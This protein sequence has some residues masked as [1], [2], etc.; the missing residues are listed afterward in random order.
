MGDPCYST[1]SPCVLQSGSMLPGSLSF[2]MFLSLML[3]LGAAFVA[4]IC[5][6]LKRNNQ[7]L[8]ELALEIN[9]RRQEEFERIRMLASPAAPMANESVAIPSAA[10][11]PLKPAIRMRATPP[12][13]PST[14]PAQ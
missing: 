14:P 8:R 9:V 3:I 13:A 11:N 4:L 10:A 1:F 2:Q 7:Q 12:K 5:A 6:H